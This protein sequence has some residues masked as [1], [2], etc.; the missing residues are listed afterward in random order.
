MPQTNLIMV[1]IILV[2]TIAVFFHGVTLGQDTFIASGD[3]WKYM[4]NGIDLSTG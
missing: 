3:E 4:A 1:R 2:A